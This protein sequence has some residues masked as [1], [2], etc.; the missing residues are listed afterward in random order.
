M[1]EK[2]LS[3]LVR[4]FD[5]FAAPFASH[6]ELKA[7]EKL[8]VSEES[9]SEVIIGR[10][11]AGLMGIA[12]TIALI[13]FLLDREKR[14]MAT[15]FPFMIYF[16]F[17]FGLMFKLSII[18]SS[19]VYQE[20]YFLS[21]IKYM[22]IV[23]DTAF[24]TWMI[25]SVINHTDHF[26]S[27]SFISGPWG[28]T[29]AFG[30][31]GAIM[32][33]VDI[34]RYD[35]LSSIYCGV[36]VLLAR[37]LITTWN[38]QLDFRIIDSSNL[39][40]I[41]SLA[42]FTLLSCLISANFRSVIMRSKKQESLERYIPDILAKELIDKG[43]D[44]SFSGDRSPVTILFSDIRNFTT[45]SE[46]VPPEEVIQFLNEYFSAMI[47]IIFDNKGMLDKIMG[48]GLMAIFGSPFTEESDPQQDAINAVN[49]AI[50]MKQKLEEFNARIAGRGY[51]PINIG[52]GIN[53]GH[54][55]L[56]SIGTEK[57]KEFTAIGDTVNTASRLESYTKEIDT[58]I[59][60]SDETR[61]HLKG[62]FSLERIGLISLK[63]KK[64]EVEAHKVLV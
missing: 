40:L 56:G 13:F 9:K 16:I 18:D 64:E 52:I 34:F 32:I 25:N 1:N 36:I 31:F 21:W 8:L 3:P 58:N 10:F 55:V 42:L 63:G 24:F 62:E 7:I 6:R 12:F 20:K 53:T 15:L 50:E 33:L 19:R 14:F 45:F 29:A 59:L 54:A 11:R 22:L 44:L 4:V 23:Y 60:I 41:A 17:S 48:D 26:R 35:F 61:K 49:T 51:D 46:Q 5:Y 57:R 38:S 37:W 27:L 30:I 47:D 39:V 43:E 28:L 2:N